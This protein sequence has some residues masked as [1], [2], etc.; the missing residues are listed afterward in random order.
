MPLK[1][2]IILLLF[3]T[4]PGYSVAA[5]RESSELMVVANTNSL[6]QYQ[7]DGVNKGP[8]IE[9]LNGILTEAQ[10]QADVSFMPWARA[11][12]IANNRP[13]TLILSMIRTAER[14]S[15]F[16]WLLKVSHIVR[17]F[18]SLKSKPENYVDSIEQ[19]KQKIIAVILDSA[20]HKELTIAG[21]SEQEN[22]YIVSSDEQMVKLL[23]T[24]RVDL[25]YTDPN[26]VTSYLKKINMPHVEIRYKEISVQNQ[27]NGYI[28]LSINS[29]KEIVEQLQ[30][31]A[32]RF[33]KTTEYTSLLLQ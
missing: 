22:L 10:L 23:A 24:G 5:S 20:A 31:A 14:E 27:R 12:S 13:N 6:L 19:A 9:I 30:Q 3:T 17:V 2:I 25:V 11:F 1:V 18:I 29:D 32:K 4:Q 21:F 8:S 16:Y 7:D 15:S 28:G 26:N 33:S